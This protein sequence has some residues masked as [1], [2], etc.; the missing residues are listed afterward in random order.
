MAR[1]FFKNLEIAE[2]EF[3]N[4][5]SPPSFRLKELNIATNLLKDYDFAN[6]ASIDI[7]ICRLKKITFFAASQALIK[8]GHLLFLV[9]LLFLP[10]GFN[11]IL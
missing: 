11:P 3:D 5:F 9:I 2:N 7:L 1:P 4:F 8:L 6:I 10:L